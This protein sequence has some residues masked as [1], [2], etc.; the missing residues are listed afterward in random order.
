[1]AAIYV[2]MSEYSYS[3]EVLL[4]VLIIFHR[5]IY[6]MNLNVEQFKR[7]L[8]I[9][10][11]RKNEPYVDTAGLLTA[12]V[13]HLLTDNEKRQFPKGTIVSQEQINT[14]LDSDIR[15][16]YELGKAILGAAEFEKLDD[17]RKRA[18][19]NLAF[20]LGNRLASF[21]KFIAAM[22]TG[23]YQVAANELVD[24]KWYKQVNQR[25]PE[26]VEQIRSGRNIGRIA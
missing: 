20:N 14:W 6:K 5:L 18:I 7:E 25:G 26:V 10:E 9:Q 21:K 11:G 17:V 24:S 23:N 19:C 2:C 8:I 15:K 16:A 4:A 22:K 13:G 1:M 12:G 3:C